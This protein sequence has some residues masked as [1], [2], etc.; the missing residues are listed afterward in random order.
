MSWGA[1]GGGEEHR[2]HAD[3]WHTSHSK[4]APL[5]NPSREDSGRALVWAASLPGVE[6]QKAHRRS[7]VFP[8]ALTPASCTF[9]PA[10]ITM[11]APKYILGPMRLLYA[12]ETQT[13][14]LHYPY[15]AGIPLSAR[16]N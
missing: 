10:H 12:P 16:C 5:S 1:G 13:K 2:G 4:L 6:V 8:G 11:R 7:L 14:H 9:K 3:R 15:L